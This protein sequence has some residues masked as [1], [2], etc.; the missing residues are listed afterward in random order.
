MKYMTKFFQGFNH[1]YL[2]EDYIDG[3]GYH[4]DQDHDD[5]DDDDW[6]IDLN[7]NQFAAQFL[8]EAKLC[9][10]TLDTKTYRC[11]IKRVYE[12]KRIV[13]GV[14][15]GGI[16]RYIASTHCLKYIYENMHILFN[17]FIFRIVQSLTMKKFRDSALK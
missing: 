16:L 8:S 3:G 9:S 14:G 15:G 12:E 17:L 7:L 1:N 10:W 2:D 4:Q 6:L 13:V 11:G 5:D